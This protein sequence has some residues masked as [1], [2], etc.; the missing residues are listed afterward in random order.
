[1]ETWTLDVTAQNFR[2]E[3]IERSN[4]TPVIV[5]FWAEW[6]DPCKELGPALE[7][8]AREGKGRF[9]LAKVDVDKNPELAQ[10]FQVQG[11]PMVL[12][13]RDGKVA[14]GFQG[15]APGAPYD[16]IHVGAA[17]ERTPEALKQQLKP[18]G[19]LVLPV[20][21]AG[22]QA[23]VRITRS[24]DGA[25]WREERLMGVRYVPLTS[26]AAQL[27]GIRDHQGPSSRGV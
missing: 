25:S 12:G 13:V 16:C 19:V 10:A 1:M 7:A 8:A 4:T 18:G 17:P 15:Y 21:P 26:A 6:C 5:A 3:V 27:G 20:G 9:I 23:F 22:D 24:A 14:D 11:I 2:E